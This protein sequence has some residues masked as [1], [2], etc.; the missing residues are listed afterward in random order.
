MTIPVFVVYA[1]IFSGSP[2]EAKLC[3]TPKFRK[4]GDSPPKKKNLAIGRYSRAAF[5]A[6]SGLAAFL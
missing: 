1:Q 3:S 2:K 6:D 4:R 5:Q